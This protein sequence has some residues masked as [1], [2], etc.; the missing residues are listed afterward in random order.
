MTAGDTARK[1]GTRSS[2]R[3]DHPGEEVRAAVA[4]LRELRRAIA[5]RR[6]H[7]PA[8]TDAEIRSLIEEGRR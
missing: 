6:R 3:L 1:A 8:F 5:A 2:R 4:G 7:L